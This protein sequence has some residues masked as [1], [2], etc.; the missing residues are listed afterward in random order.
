MVRASPFRGKR[1]LCVPLQCE[2]AKGEI[3]SLP[4]NGKSKAA[5]SNGSHEELISLSSFD[6]LRRE[7]RFT[8]HEAR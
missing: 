7:L 2:I 5:L 3:N 4:R 1:E 6:V 8:C